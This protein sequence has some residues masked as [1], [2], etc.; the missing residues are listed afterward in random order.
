M[1]WQGRRTALVTGGGSGIGRAICLELAARGWHVVVAD[2]D[3]GAGQETLSRIEAIG[4]VGGFERLDVTREEHW[5]DLVERLRREWSGLDLLVNNAGVCAGGALDAMSVE[6]WDWVHEVN[7]RGAMLGCRACIPWLKENPRKSYIMNVA[8]V[9]GLIHAPRMAAYN[10][11]KAALVALTETLSHELHENNISVTAV[12]PWFSPT[13]LA[14]AGRFCHAAEEQFAITQMENSAVTPEQ[15]AREGLRATLAGKVI[16]VVGRPAR[17]L[18]FMQRLSPG[19]LRWLI[20]LWIRQAVSRQST[21]VEA[22]RSA[23]TVAAEAPALH[24]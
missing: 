24:E 18:R 11:S 7:L 14:R 22:E 12:C 15:I 4:G 1:N 10:A 9:A 8:S 6:T 5:S 3:L 13:N 17:W 21:V 19:L 20:R 2:I 23:S 16:C